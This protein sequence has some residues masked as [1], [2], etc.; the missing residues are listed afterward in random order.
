MGVSAAAA[1]RASAPLVAECHEE[2]D[3]PTKQDTVA[4]YKRVNTIV[5]QRLSPTFGIRTINAI[6]KNAI[7]RL[8]KQHPYLTRLQVAADGLEWTQFEARLDLVDEEAVGAMLDALMD[9]FLEALA[10]LIGRLMVGKIFAEAKEAA[11]KE[12]RR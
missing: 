5:W 9:E 7:V 8:S 2:L 12:V 10:T 6:A 4:I 11:E 1:L 3:V